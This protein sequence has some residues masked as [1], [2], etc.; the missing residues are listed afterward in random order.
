M[1]IGFLD[2]VRNGRC[3]GWLADQEYPHK[4][5]SVSLY[6]NDNNCIAKGVADGHRPDLEPL[7]LGVLHGFDFQI[8]GDLKTA[9]ISLIVDNESHESYPFKYNRIPD[10][11]VFQLSVCAI[12]KNEGRD[13]A[14][15]IAFHILQGV[16]HFFIFDNGSTDDTVEQIRRFPDSLVTLIDW[17][18]RPGQQAAYMYAVSSFREYSQWM[19]FID[20]DEFLFSP[21]GEDLRIA[22]SFYLSYSAVVVHWVSY[23]TGG[24]KSRDCNELVIQAFTRRAPDLFWMNRYVKSVINPRS[25]VGACITPHVFVTTGS[26]VNEARK[27]VNHSSGGIDED[28][29]I[30]IFRIN[31][32]PVKDLRSWENKMCRGFADQGGNRNDSM[33]EYYDSAERNS[34]T[35]DILF[36]YSGPIHRLLKDRSQ[37]IYK[38]LYD[39]RIDHKIRIDPSDYEFIFD[40][41]DGFENKRSWY[42]RKRIKDFQAD[43]TV[44]MKS[45]SES[46]AK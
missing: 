17:P 33:F 15:W 31:H 21:K 39:T 14:E 38:F 12:V 2:G 3:F 1:L 11:P 8:E 22:L 27:I 16:E 40:A 5:L 18:I 24:I 43:A 28:I 42:W 41:L 32:Y 36:E 19:A 46:N 26:A 34:V 45:G 9:D 23:G 37:G 13:I 25:V 20:A 10:A 4:S 30:E 29:T 6:D 35:D 7:G 44:G